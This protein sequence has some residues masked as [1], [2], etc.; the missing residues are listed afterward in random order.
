MP[1]G[2]RPRFPQSRVAGEERLAPGEH[3]KCPASHE[4]CPHLSRQF[5]KHALG[6]ISGHGASEAL[7]HHNAD[8]SVPVAR[9]TGEQIEQRGLK[10]AAVPLDTLD[11]CASPQEETAV[12][13]RA[14]HQHDTI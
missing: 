3:H 12:F 4:L 7:A 5:S 13:R 11:V 10:A 6:S 2:R 1:Q 14:S 8:T 9:G